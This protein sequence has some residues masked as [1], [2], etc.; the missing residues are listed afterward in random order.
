[1]SHQASQMGQATLKK[2]IVS[3]P[4]AGC[5]YYFR[6]GTFFFS[7]CPKQHFFFSFCPKQ[8]FLVKISSFSYQKKKGQKKKRFC[9]RPTGQNFSHPLDR[10]QTFLR[11]ASVV[12]VFSEIKVKT[13]RIKH[14]PW[15]QVLVVHLINPCWLQISQPGSRSFSRP[16]E[17]WRRCQ[18]RV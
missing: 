8:H 10:K 5:V 16:P 1:M 18:V 9:D 15:P 11:V 12:H 6:M 14:S 7:F 13:G 3:G 2:N 17:S 4:A